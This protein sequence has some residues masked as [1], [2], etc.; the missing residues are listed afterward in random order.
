MPTFLRWSEPTITFDRTDHP[1]S[2]PQPVRYLL[3]VDL[4]VDKK[5]LIEVLMDGSSSLNILYAETLDAMGIDRSRIRS[6]R[7]PFHDIMPAKQAMML[8]QIDLPITFGNLTNYRMET[9]TFEVVGFHMTYH[10]ILR[11]PCYAKFM[12][13]PNYTYLK[14]NMPGPQGVITMDTSFQH[15][16]EWEVECYE[17]AATIIAST[18]ITT[19]WERTIG[20]PLDSK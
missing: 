18:K 4:I 19:I 17:H 12:A 9:L 14:L 11:R 7:A 16:Y 13:I 10:T 8:G 1:N 3:I 2:V 5:W 20:E 6:T 15:A